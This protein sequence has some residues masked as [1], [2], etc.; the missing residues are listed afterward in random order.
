MSSLDPGMPIKRTVRFE[1][2]FNTEEQK[3]L[4]R[5]VTVVSGWRDEEL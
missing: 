3:S 2:D 4:A 5:K 1:V